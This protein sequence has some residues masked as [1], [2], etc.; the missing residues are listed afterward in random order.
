MMND[1]GKKM[2]ND[3]CRMMNEKTLAADVDF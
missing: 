3:E 2:M 1:E